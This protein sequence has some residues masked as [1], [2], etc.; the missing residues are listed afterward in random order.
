MRF[1]SL[2]LSIGLLIPACLGVRYETLTSKYKKNILKITDANYQNLLNNEDFDIVLY[3]TASSPQVGCVLCNEFQPVFEQLA[4]SFYENLE[5]HGLGSDD[6]KLIFAYSDFPDSRKLFQQLALNNVPKIYYYNAQQGIGLKPS[7]EFMFMSTDLLS[8]LTSWL[9]AKTH[10][11]PELFNLRTKVNYTE[12]LLTFCIVFG[13][14]VTIILNYKRVLAII[15]NKRG[16]QALSILLVI[17]FTSGYMFNLIRNTQYIRTN[18]DGSNIYFIGGHQ[19][20]LG[21]ETQIISV[22]YGLFCA[23]MV[24]LVDLFK[25]F[26]NAKLRLFSSVGLSIGL[27]V[28]YS[29]LV[30]CFHA[31]NTGY[32]YWLLKF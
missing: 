7:D 24:I 8:T 20:Q 27:F 1:A 3:L 14:G 29:I 16:W 25:K 9:V 30:T 19:A 6:T 23:G 12:L 13:L 10:L 22:I 4:A 28:L 15:T 18:K 5:T 32:P 26:D 2:L 31:K 21:V 17:L 11:S